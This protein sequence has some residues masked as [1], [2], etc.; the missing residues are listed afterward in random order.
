MSETGFQVEE[1][2]GEI[3]VMRADLLFI[4]NLLQEGERVSARP[5]TSHGHQ[6]PCHCSLE[7]FRQ[8]SPRRASSGGLCEWYTPLAGACGG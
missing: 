5:K 8:Q 2:D 1:R 4:A 7:L 6:R 3:I